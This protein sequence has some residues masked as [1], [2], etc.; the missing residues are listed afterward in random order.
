MLAI[1]GSVVTASRSFHAPTGIEGASQVELGWETP[2]EVPI[3]ELRL[4]HR[5]I[6]IE[7]LSKCVVEGPLAIQRFE[8]GVYWSDL[9]RLS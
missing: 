8:V 7:E 6:S 1:D 4:N 2:K 9:T 5:C 3:V